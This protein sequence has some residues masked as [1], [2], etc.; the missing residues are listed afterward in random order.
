MNMC[1]QV[2]IIVLMLLGSLALPYCVSAEPGGEVFPA[3]PAIIQAVNDFAGILSPDEQSLLEQ[4]LRGYERSSSCEITMVTV[5]TLG[6]YEVAQYTVQLANA[7][8]LGKAGKDNG[9]LL[10]AAMQEHKVS[11][12]V[13]RGLEDKLTDLTSGRII[14]NEIVPAFRNEQYF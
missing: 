10:L 5:P 8:K 14:R 7:W 3:K 4:K 1:K 6:T 9:V 13:G 12:Q 11:I 2:W